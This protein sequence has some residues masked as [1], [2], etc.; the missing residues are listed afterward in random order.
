MTI[1]YETG[2]IVLFEGEPW[3]VSR[4]MRVGSDESLFLELENGERRASALAIACESFLP[5]SVLL[6]GPEEVWRASNACGISGEFMVERVNGEGV[7]GILCADVDRYVYFSWSGWRDAILIG[8]MTLIEPKIAVPKCSAPTPHFTRRELCKKGDPCRFCVQGYCYKP[9]GRPLDGAQ[10]QV[11]L[12]E[13]AGSPAYVEGKSFPMPC[14]SVPLKQVQAE[15][16]ACPEPK[17]PKPHPVQTVT[18]SFVD[19][20]GRFYEV[21]PPKEAGWARSGPPHRNPD[22]HLA[23]WGAEIVHFTGAPPNDSDGKDQMPS[24]GT[25]TFEEGPPRGAYFKVEHFE[26]KCWGKD[27]VPLMQDRSVKLVWWQDWTWTPPP[28]RV[29]EEYPAARMYPLLSGREK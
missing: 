8:T 17:K 6:P 10:I 21:P 12:P 28:P 24:D 20:V 15:L 29:R 1:A 9:G 18:A 14:P 11:L 5:H 4:L 16:A 13:M 23:L 2:E 22:S 3:A 19:D 25:W 26:G 7:Y 27:M